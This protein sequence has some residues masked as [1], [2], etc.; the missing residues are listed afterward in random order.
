MR[1]KFV[2][3]LLSAGI[4]SGCATTPTVE[5]GNQASVIVKER[6][7]WMTTADAFAVAEQ[8]CQSYGRLARL[9]YREKGMF[10]FDCIPKN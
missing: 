2:L 9:N 10:Y 1:G 7:K 3:A 8:H 5:G 6:W 4:L